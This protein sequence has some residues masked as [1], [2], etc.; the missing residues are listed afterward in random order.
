MSKAKSSLTP[1]AICSSM[2]R[3]WT[4]T[5]RSKSNWCAANGRVMNRIIKGIGVVTCVYVNAKSNRFWIIDFRI[6]DRDSDRKTK[7]DYVSDMPVHALSCKKLPGGLPLSFATVLIDSWYQVRDIFVFCC[8]TGL[9]YADVEKLA[10]NQIGRGMDGKPWIFTERAKTE[11]ATRV[12]LLSPALALLEK[13]RDHPQAV[14]KGR[15]FPVM[16]NYC[17]KNNKKP[18]LNLLKI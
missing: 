7:N 4:K 11:T 18:H 10:S 3:S 13:Y 15:L 12:P 14:S 16:T 17:L 1:K 2:T 5:T 6:H 9:A 8:Y